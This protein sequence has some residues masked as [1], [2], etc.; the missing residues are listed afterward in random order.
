VN[1]FIN[2]ETYPRTL[3]ESSSFY[4]TPCRPVPAR[5]LWLRCRLQGK[6]SFGYLRQSQTLVTKAVNKFNNEF[7]E[8]ILQFLGEL[9]GAGVFVRVAA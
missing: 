1:R 6:S 9:S 2:S 8:I 7:R 5:L 3:N 4:M